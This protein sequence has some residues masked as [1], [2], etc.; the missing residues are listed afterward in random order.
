M[1]GPP[2]YKIFYNGTPAPKKECMVLINDI[3]NREKKTG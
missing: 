1:F 2:R 3:Q